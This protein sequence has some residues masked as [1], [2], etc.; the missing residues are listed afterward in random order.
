MQTP[1]AVSS[2]EPGRDGLYAL[3]ESVLTWWQPREDDPDNTIT[4][5]LSA[6]KGYVIH[7]IRIV[8]RD[9]GMETLDGI[10]P[11]PFRYVVEYQKPGSND[12]LC[13]IDCSDNERDL[14]VDYR[15]TEQVTASRLRLRIVG[16]LRGIQPGV[17]DFTAFGWC[18]H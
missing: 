9:I 6:Q 5:S 14:C 13:L 2:A 11:G 3:D 18:A 16:A 4:V 1:P 10:D 15:Q 7:S 17:C 12:W 8:W